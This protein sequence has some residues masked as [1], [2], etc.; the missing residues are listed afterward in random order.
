MFNKEIII[1]GVSAKERLVLVKQLYA[2]LHAGFPIP[3][4]LK[5]ALVQ[6]KG[7]IRQIIEDVIAR[8]DRGAYLHEAFGLYPQYFPPLFLNL[9][10]TGEVS[11]SLE[12]N[13]K[14]LATVI[15]KEIEFRQKVLS[16]M[17]YP[18]FVLIAIVG[19]GL[20]VSFL[21]LPNLL[22][23][24][25]SLGTELPFTTRVLLWFAEF[26]EAAGFYL[27]L[28]LFVFAVFLAWIY[29]RPFAKPFF[30]WFFLRFPLFGPLH[31]QITL[32]RLS[33]TLNSLLE[34]GM[35]LEN[36]LMLITSIISNYYYRRSI[37]KALPL[38]RKGESLSEALEKYPRLYDPMFVSLLAL[39]ERTG[40]L[41][42][43]FGYISEFY[44]AE[45]DEKMKNF[46]VSL[47]PVLL[48]IAGVAV[49]FVALAILSPIYQL[50]GSLR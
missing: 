21:V 11:G 23:L 50:T 2:G 43:S 37:E 22:P 33:R 42:D 28:G 38:V 12:I 19:L 48:I 1:G 4:A 13:L 44:E 47:E 31:K 41:T 49:G 24:F 15:S 39:G 36:A 16:A 7:R 32:A 9:V 26:S 10:K 5:I 14:R 17:M 3:D 40:G 34:S 29:R 18:T 6:A 35:P 30:H 46:A 45:V 20:S 27:W 25:K 8:V